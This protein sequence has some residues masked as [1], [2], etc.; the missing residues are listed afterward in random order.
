MS[1]K[2]VA[3]IIT[4]I[5]YATNPQRPDEITGQTTDMPVAECA[6]LAWKILREVENRAPQ[7]KVRP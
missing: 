3:A 2:Q 1:E 4:A 5:L 6:V 7:E